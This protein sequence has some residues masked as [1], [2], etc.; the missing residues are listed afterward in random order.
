[1]I[2]SWSCAE[3]EA[4]PTDANTSAPLDAEPVDK[5]LERRLAAAEEEACAELSQDTPRE[6]VS[7]PALR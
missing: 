6:F 3:I 2:L 7:D 1:M 4:R 5:E